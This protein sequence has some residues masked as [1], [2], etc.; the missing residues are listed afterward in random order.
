M[1]DAS[2]DELLSNNLKNNRLSFE[3]ISEKLEESSGSSVKNSRMTKSRATIK[4]N[5]NKSILKSNNDIS[6]D[7]INVSNI[8]INKVKRPTAKNSVCSKKRKTIRIFTKEENTREKDRQKTFKREAK[9]KSTQYIPKRT[10]FQHDYGHLFYNQ[11]REDAKRNSNNN[12]PPSDNNVKKSFLREQSLNVSS[13][14]NNKL[15]IITTTLYNNK[16]SIVENIMQKNKNANLSNSEY[17]DKKYFHN[18][19]TKN[20]VLNKNKLNLKNQRGM[21][22]SVLFEKLRDSYLFEKSENVLYKIKI[23]YGFLAAFSFLSILLQVIDVIIF[24]KESQNFVR[25]NYNIH[26]IDNTNITEYYFIEERKLT[27]RENNIRVLNSIFSVI[28]LALHLFIHF[29]KNNFDKETKKKGRKKNYYYNYNRRRKTRMGVKDATSTENKLKII[30]NDDF[31]TKNFVTREE[32]IKLVI[33]CIISV[34]FYPPGINKVFIGFQNDVIYVY[35]LNSIFLLMTFFKLINIY[36]AIYYLSPFNNLLYKTICSSNMVKMNLQFMFR[37]LLNLYPMPFILINF[38]TIG[39]VI[40]L[41]IFSFEYFSINVNGI[42]NSAGENDLKNF[43][44]EIYLYLSFII[45]SIHGNIKPETILGYLVFFLG[46]AIGLVINSYLI[47]YLSRLTEFNPEEQQ[48]YSKLVKLLNPINNEH[49]ASNFIKIFLLM[50]KMHIDNR[51][52]E[53]EYKLKRDHNFRNLE[54]NLE[55]K[56]SKFNLVNN[57]MENSISNA[58]LNNEYK[59]KK[60]LIKYI[61]T[62]FVFKVKLINECKNFRNILLI[63]RNYSL[64]FND[65]LKTLED[66]MN[67][68][69][70]QL[71]NKLEILIQ[72]DQKF[73]NF[74]RFQENSLKKLK[75]IMVY[76]D[77]LLSYLIGVNNEIGAHYI[78]DNKEMQNNF[79]NKMKNMAGGP[80]RM[81]SLIN[82]S[83]FAFSK[84]KPQRKASIEE[85]MDPK[86]NNN[87]K[88]NKNL[89]ILFEAP[90]Q[91]GCKRLKSSV[92]ANK[93]NYNNI[94]EHNK[95]KTIPIKKKFVVKKNTNVKKSTSIDNNTLK[96]Y[97]KNNIIDKIESDEKEKIGKKRRSSSGKQ[98]EKIEK[99]LNEIEKKNN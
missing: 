31:V 29:I 5:N 54:K 8:S 77:L 40:S 79:K 52:M 34:I 96:N 98:K 48:A 13:L 70:N 78:R 73:K 67:G 46:G 42:W 9:K 82:G 69:L 30:T 97:C 68:N 55:Q 15:S 26:L 27:K 35:S 62:Q 21:N 2:N 59:E 66:K 37:F 1:I 65:V 32:I 25:E 56:D 86:I 90:K 63:A 53:D 11:L 76:Q 57:E 45:K 83:I 18:R 28:S 44:N 75:K 24:N 36:F 14:T 61:S 89:K 95:S 17:L 84:K 80:R 6:K 74:M 87:N 43:Y 38:I 41:L 71:N 49:K 22:F 64:S 85:G 94:N 19:K 33:N 72:N 51:N 88:D 12:M 81:K 60:K 23:C 3:S 10:S 58:G 7:N 50:K 92:L 91:L 99:L 4:N 93:N 16:N 47:F 39:I 20:T